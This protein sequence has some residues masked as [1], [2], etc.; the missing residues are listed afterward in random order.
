MAQHFKDAL[1]QFQEFLKIYNMLSS[2][3]LDDQI[4]QFI[5]QYYSIIVIITL[6]IAFDMITKNPDCQLSKQILNYN[7]SIYICVF[8]LYFGHQNL[9]SFIFV[10]LLMKY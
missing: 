5:F 4:F 9:A 1:A 3:Q 2:I 6:F 10:Y 8:L 7:K